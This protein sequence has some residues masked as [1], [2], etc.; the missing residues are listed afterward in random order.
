[1]YDFSD[2]S[3]E[4]LKE[5]ERLFS[6][7]EDFGIYQDEDMIYEVNEEIRKKQEVSIR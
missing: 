7:L 4:D 6:K 5:I 2:Y 1:M 3:L